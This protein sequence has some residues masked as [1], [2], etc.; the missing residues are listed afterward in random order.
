MWTLLT[1]V[2]MY[3]RS[4]DI[5]SANTEYVYKG[6]LPLVVVDKLPRHLDKPSRVFL[7]SARTVKLFQTYMYA[8][9]WISTA[10]NLVFPYLFSS[11]YMCVR[12]KSFP[13]LLWGKHQRESARILLGLG[14]L[15]CGTAPVISSSSLSNLPRKGLWHPLLTYA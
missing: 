9:H 8:Y 11:L 14:L 15:L 6:S 3:I 13:A 2:I 12:N 4:I 7:P 10:R 1:S 5:N